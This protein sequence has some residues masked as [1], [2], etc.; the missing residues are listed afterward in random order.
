MMIYTENPKESTKEKKNP[1]IK[2][3]SKVGEYKH[4]EIIFLYIIEHVETLKIQ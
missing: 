3:F 1:R 4:T 2:E